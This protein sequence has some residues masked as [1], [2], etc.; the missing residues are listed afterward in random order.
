MERF[1]KATF[2]LTAFNTS[3]GIL[4]F[5]HENDSRDDVVGVVLP[6]D[7]FAGHG[8]DDDMRNVLNRMG[9]PLRDA[10]T[11][12]PMSSLDRRR[13]MP[14]IKFLSGAL[15]DLAAADVGIARPSAA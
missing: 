8:T 12:W 5:A 13:P 7:P 9:V 2:A 3:L 11:T 10:T 1:N 6:D 14:R 15:L 4:A